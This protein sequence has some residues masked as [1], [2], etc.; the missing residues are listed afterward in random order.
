MQNSGNQALAGDITVESAVAFS[1]ALIMAFHICDD[2]NMPLLPE[3]KKHIL[4]C[5]MT[6]IVDM[7]DRIKNIIEL[8]DVARNLADFP[9]E[10]SRV[11]EIV[12]VVDGEDND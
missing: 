10:A 2:I 1:D 11:E 9:K 12:V 8:D 7:R 6:V 5:S 4:S 3:Q